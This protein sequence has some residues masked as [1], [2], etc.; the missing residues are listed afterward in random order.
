MGITE[1][2]EANNGVM[3]LG[4]L[5]SKFAGLKKAQLEGHFEVEHGEKDTIVRVF[6]AEGEPTASNLEEGPRKRRKR[7]KRSK[8]APP[9]G[10]LDDEMLSEITDY[11]NDCGGSAPLGKVTTAFEGVKKAQLEEN[12]VVTQGADAA[13]TDPIVSLS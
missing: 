9:P 7:D 13:N 12:F 3:F 1:T 5:A 11:L 10:P 4:R 2:L 8:D 6:G